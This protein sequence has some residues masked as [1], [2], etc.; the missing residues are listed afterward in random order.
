MFTDVRG[1]V[2]TT[3]SQVAAESCSLAIANYCAR[4][5]DTAATLKQA[6]EADEACVLG[7]AMTGL[8]IC[9][10]RKNAAVPLAQ[11]AY[12]KAL[13]YRASASRREQLYVDALQLALKRQPDKLLSCYESILSEYP[14]DLLALA[15]AQGEAFWAGDMAHSEQLSR[16]T[17]S[18]W[19]P[20]TE[21]YVDWLAVRAFDLEETGDLICAERLGRQAVE[22][23]PTNTWAAHAVAH[24][25]EM[26]GE[27]KAGVQW[28]DGLQHHWQDANQLKFHLWWHRC[29]CH[30]ECQEYDVVLEIYDSWIR[31]P[32]H[33]L[34]QALPD[35]YLDI[36]NAASILMRLELAGTPVGSRWEE[37]ASAIDPAY[38]DITSPFTSA[39]S[40]MTFAA[41]GDFARLDRMLDEIEL[42][43]SSEGALA[44]AYKRSIPVI[45]GI[46]AH[47]LENHAMV[48][49]L[50]IPARNTLWELG[51]SHA[52][53][54]ILFQIMFDSAKRLK[55]KKLVK[56]LHHDLERIG[57]V[58]PEN[59]AAYQL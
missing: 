17:V 21:G 46:K 3:S 37:L 16:S 8:M 33:P 38:L 9:S 23:D 29:L 52:Q 27:S 53:R 2:I 31:N 47:R 50:M 30:V 56:S 51:G 26:R 41:I 24:V 11:A 7:Q 22:L 39:H 5:S 48:L 18:R 13:E 49:D 14:T 36:Q 35:F 42:F 57:F 32:S 4:R 54:D 1:H 58:N 10:L 59:R 45:K 20:S 40:A 44:N 28:L 12:T 43:A 19:D 15:M 55:R 34:M 6:I 25:L